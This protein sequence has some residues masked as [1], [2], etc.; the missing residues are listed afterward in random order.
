MTDSRFQSESLRRF[1]IA[2][3]MLALLAGTTAAAWWI[4][5]RSGGFEMPEQ[6]QSHQVGVFSFD[7]P[8]DWRLQQRAAREMRL[9]HPGNDQIRLRILEGIFPVATDPKSLL[10]VM[11]RQQLGIPTITRWSN[12]ESGRLAHYF[13]AAS[14]GIMRGQR[15]DDGTLVEQ[16]HYV[17]VIT[18]DGH[19]HLV[20]HFIKPGNPNRGDMNF[21]RWVAGTASDVRY[22][23]SGEQDITMGPVEFDLP[24]ELI[25]LIPAEGSR[26]QD[27]RVV[28]RDGAEMLAMQ[29]R[30]VSFLPDS[31]DEVITPQSLEPYLIQYL[32]QQFNRMT[33][34]PP[35]QAEIVERQIDQ[36]IAYSVEV[37]PRQ[38]SAREEI[39]VIGLNN[40]IGLV[41]GLT[42]ERAIFEKARTQLVEMID[43]IVLHE[44]D[45]AQPMPADEPETPE[46]ELPELPDHQ[47]IEGEP[48]S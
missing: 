6:T 30:G 26:A 12:A 19:R 18:M 17:L 31:A 24:D 40:Q 34:R 36:R 48:V 41:V 44:G 13:Y 23:L 4:A 27:M 45:D 5:D 1:V 3:I 21:L 15:T 7:M 11:S 25:A 28:S 10:E 8:S 9:V 47:S 38:A 42:A 33:G 37:T 43:Q 22:Q 29:V 39:W 16:I 2:S 14:T 46:T 20:F 32:G 35:A